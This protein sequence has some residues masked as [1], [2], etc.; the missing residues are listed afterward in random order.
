MVQRCLEGKVAV[1]T[2][3][4]HGIGRFEALALAELG[5]RVV[6]AD[7]GVDAQGSSLA[8]LVADEVVA[9]GGAAA[10]STA[11]LS[12]ATGARS[13]IEA[14]VEQ[15]GG[16]DIL[17]NNAGMRGGNPVDRLSDDQ[18]DQVI[19]SH[20]TASFLTIRQAV[21]YMRRRGGGVIINTGS[22]A[23]LG[24]PFNAAYAAAKE[25]I[26]G[27]TRSVAR[28]QGRFNIRC[29][30]IRP[31]ATGGSV[32]GGDWFQKN[33]AGTW[34]P[35]LDRLGRYWIGERGAARWDKPATPASVAALV[36]W[37]CTPAASNINGQDFF[38]GGEEI[39]LLTPPAF[40]A[41]LVRDG[42][43]TVEALDR[44]AP[45]IT[46]QLVDHFRVENPFTEGDW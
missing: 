38:V 46:G 17:V 42:D 32:G 10:T 44:C 8:A 20:L 40:S 29:N 12:Q 39:A 13:T 4:G 5:A 9:A 18:W 24:M 34:K 1:V 3:A 45:A 26:A 31:R 41:T 36:A 11:D 30:L 16:I 35:L 6:I 43:W 27:L 15:F 25:G 14:A 22:E 19:S 28:E 2:G 37:L 23:G 7:F 33:L 21:P